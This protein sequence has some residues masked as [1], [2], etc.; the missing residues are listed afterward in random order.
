MRVKKLTE[1]EFMRQVL[2]Y[3]KLT[4]WLRV[5]FRP[6]MTKTGW[7]TAVEGDGVGFPDCLLLRRNRLVVAELKTPGKSMTPAQSEW[8]KAFAEAGAETYLWRPADWEAIERI[9]A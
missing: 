9:L 5:H 6:A 2:E 4:G 1:R 7:R 3:A 8:L